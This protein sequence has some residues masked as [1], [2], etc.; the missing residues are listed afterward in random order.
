MHIKLEL[1]K[2]EVSEYVARHMD[3]LDIDADKIADTVAIS[4]LSEIQ[5][6]IQNDDISDFDAVEEIVCIFEKYK[7]NAGPR[8][9]FG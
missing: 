4:A 6:V 7:I 9:D 5:E 2:A 3:R 1:L 8:H